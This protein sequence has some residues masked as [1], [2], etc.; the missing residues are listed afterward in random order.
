MTDLDSAGSL[1]LN[2]FMPC[3]ISQ[4][5]LILLNSVIYVYNIFI[6]SHM[7]QDIQKNSRETVNLIVEPNNLA[8]KLCFPF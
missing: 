5:F 7:A 6:T 8:K 3:K 4:F 2:L 1:Y